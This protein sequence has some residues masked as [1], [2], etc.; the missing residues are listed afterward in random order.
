VLVT[1]I[2]WKSKASY[3]P[4]KVNKEIQINGSGGGGDDDDDDDDDDY[5]NVDGTICFQA[6]DTVKTITGTLTTYLLKLMV[7]ECNM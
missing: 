4:H 3:V 1:Y 2:F 7:S 6:A 5:D